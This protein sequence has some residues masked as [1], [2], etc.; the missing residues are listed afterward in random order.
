MNWASSRITA[1]KVE[2]LQ[3][4]QIAPE[5]RV[6]GDD[7]VV[8]RDLLAQVV[9]RG[10]AFEHEHL[11]VGVN[12]SASRRQLCSTD[13]GQMTRTG[14]GFLLVAILEPR[15]PGER[16]QRFAETHVVGEDAAELRMLVRWQRKSKPSF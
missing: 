7:D 15:E 16:L 11:E 1:R 14:L 8:L 5:Q 3:L 6:V 12:F 4:L 9:P 2:L 13:A 10:A